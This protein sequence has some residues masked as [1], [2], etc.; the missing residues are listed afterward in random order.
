MSTCPCCGQ[1]MRVDR[2]LLDL[3]NNVLV[4][5]DNAVKLGPQPAEL[6]AILLEAYPRTVPRGVII[7]R[8]WGVREPAFADNIVRINTCRLRKKLAP[9]GISVE[10]LPKIGLRLVIEKELRHAA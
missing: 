6:A 7:E 10:A 9:L 4:F 2:P 8:L 1:N 5:R 3:N